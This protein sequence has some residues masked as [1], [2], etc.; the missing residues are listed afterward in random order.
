MTRPSSVVL[1]GPPGAGKGTQAQKLSKTLSIPH[2]STGDILRQVRQ[3]GGPLGQ[4][5]SEIM[6][7]G[8][9]VP[10]ELVVRIVEA[11]LA[12]A[13]CDNGFILDGFP[14]TIAQAQA[15]D[16]ILDEQNKSLN[17]VISLEVD[18]NELVNRLSGRRSC[19]K[20]GR[21]YH[22]KFNP[23]KRDSYCDDCVDQPLHEREDDKEATVRERLRVYRAETAP[24]VAYYDAEHLLKRVDGQQDPEQVF[25][26]ILS[27]V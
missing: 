1:F 2:I 8:E 22:L 25:Q 12:Q 11:R 6:N 13:D 4:E 16:R 10:A 20:C 14:R 24:L 18:E 26:A 5:V 23:P 15:L 7:R 9:L 19:P 17:S 21:A 27:L 3:E